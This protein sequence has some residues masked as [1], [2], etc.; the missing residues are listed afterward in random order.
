[1]SVKELPALDKQRQ[2]TTSF[3]YEQLLRAI[4]EGHLPPG[5]RLREQELVDW[6]GISRTPVREALRRLHAEGLVE[7]LSYKG[8]VVRPLDPDEV[9]EEYVLRAAL[10]G[11]ATELAVQRM[12]DTDLERLEQLAADLERALDAQDA[13]EYLE[14]NFTFHFTL[15]ALSGST[16]LMAGIDASWKKDNLYRRVAYTLPGGWDEE[17]KFHRDLMAACRARDAE[18]ARRLVQRSCLE[19]SQMLVKTIRSASSETEA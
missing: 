13:E 3:A 15:Y 4:L 9:R 11:M 7:I 2:T 14:T 12:S 10:E 16:R 5:S 17:R 19:F 18:Q 8:A 6:L 1:M